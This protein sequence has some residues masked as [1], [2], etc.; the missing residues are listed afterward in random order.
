LLDRRLDH[1]LSLP[2]PA[3]SS[4]HEDSAFVIS[5]EDWGEVALP[6][7][8]FNAP[9]RSRNFGIGNTGEL[10]IDHSV[11]VGLAA[12]ASISGYS[13]PAEDNV[14]TIRISKRLRP[15]KGRASFR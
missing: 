14:M 6:L 4:T 10:R 13:I 3:R 11:P 9:A 8:W 7:A 1:G 5:P 12:G 15:R 2:S